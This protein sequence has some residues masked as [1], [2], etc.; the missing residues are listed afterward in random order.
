MPD[1]SK[2]HDTVGRR[3][4]KLAI[5][6]DL[7]GA[8][9]RLQYRLFQVRALWRR[10]LSAVGPRAILAAVRRKR[11]PQIVS[12]GVNC[13]VAFRFYRRWGFV[14]SSV[15]A[16]AAS[17]NLAT[18]VAALRNLPSVYEGAFSINERTHMW[19][20]ADCGIRFHGNLKWKLGSPMPPRE[21]LDADLDD[22]RGRLR[23]L[24][25]KLVRYLRSD[26]ETLL[27]HKLANEDAE[28]SDLD[29][30]LD[31]L[32]DAIAALGARNWRMLVV[33]RSADMPR[34]PRT[35]NR[36]IYRSVREFNPGSK[37]TW[38]ELGDPVGWHALFSEFA[39]KTILKKAHAFKFE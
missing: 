35:S 32:E 29:A 36:R 21:A 22:L 24:S 18:L 3:Q 33:C 17:Q 6:M 12:L 15:F 13:E 10:V 28:A 4:S 14:D 31:A 19:M 16:W 7:Y 1:M 20:N 37:V 9:T 34:M 8:Q 25:E 38:A 30:R 23:H 26:E 2:N 39:P 27:V 11:Y 5:K